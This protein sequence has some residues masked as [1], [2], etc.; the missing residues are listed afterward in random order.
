MR[1]IIPATLLFA[2]LFGPP[3]KAQEETPTA[4]S[5]FDAALA[6]FESSRVALRKWQYH[7]TLVTE[8]LDS[9]GHLVAKGMWRSIVRPGDPRPLEYLNE[10]M[11]GKLSFFKAGAEEQEAGASK[12]ATPKIKTATDPDKNQAE[13]AVEAVRKY[14]LRDRYDWMRL[15]DENLAGEKAYVLTFR[16]KPKQNV[17]SREERFF[18]L[19]AG[20]LWVSQT[21]STVLKAEAA[22]QSPCNL[23]W[24]IARVTTFQVNYEAD[25]PH[26]SNRLLLLTNQ[27]QLFV[28]QV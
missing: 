12:G 10:K 11:E 18:G 27:T 3:A 6:Q 28:E 16:P 21:D 8:Q 22:L 13:S 15:P 9:A 1:R 2:L 14:H 4:L 5:I 25:P 26:S 7:Q 23:F 24:V 17:K 20:R 19:L